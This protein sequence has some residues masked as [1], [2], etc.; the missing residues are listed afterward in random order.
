MREQDQ[1]T[2]IFTLSNMMM[3]G[4]L[5]ALRELGLTV[6]GDVSVVGIDDFDFANI[7]NPPPTVVAAP[8]VMAER[9]IEALFDEIKR[10]EGPRGSQERFEPRLIVRESARAM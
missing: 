9:A 7:M 6:P 1:P 4:V 5:N 10:K 2:A 3:L 8:V